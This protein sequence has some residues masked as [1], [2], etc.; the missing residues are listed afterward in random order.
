[1]ERLFTFLAGAA[2]GA[3]AAGL[4]ASEI[5]EPTR[6]GRRIDVLSAPGPNTVHL[7]ARIQGLV[8]EIRALTRHADARKARARPRAE[9]PL[10]DESWRAEGKGYAWLARAI[11]LCCGCVAVGLGTRRGGGH[12]AALAAGGA[13]MILGEAAQAAG[14]LL[15]LTDILRSPEDWQGYGTGARTGAK[16][17]T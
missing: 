8:G 11:F 1:L 14:R 4:V 17:E 3:G 16:A 10:A 5:A 12:G 6:G 13:L 15:P 7:L 9:G 2:L